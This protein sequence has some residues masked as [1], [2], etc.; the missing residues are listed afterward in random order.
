MLG[1]LIYRGALKINLS[2]F[3][4]WTGAF[5]ILVA[6]GVLA[7][8]VHDLQEAGFLPGLNNLAFDVSACIPPTSWY[9]T[10][11]K[12]IFNFSPATTVLEAVA[13]LLYVV[14]TLTIFL[15]QRRQRTQPAPPRPHA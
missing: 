4:T 2:R 9:G 1:Y 11:L 3:F 10:L 8:G 14:P 5:L 6:A 13:W 7:Y 15:Y 12:G